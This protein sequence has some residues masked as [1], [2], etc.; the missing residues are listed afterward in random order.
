MASALFTKLERNVVRLV[1]K[2]YNKVNTVKT[3]SDSIPE[4]KC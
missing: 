2:I 1:I 3:G 4:N